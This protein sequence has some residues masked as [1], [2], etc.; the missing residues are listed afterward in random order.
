MSRIHCILALVA[1]LISVCTLVAQGND[2]L[3]DVYLDVNDVRDLGYDGERIWVATTGGAVAFDPES[4]KYD[5]L[6]R[7]SGGLLSDSLTAVQIDHTGRIWFGTERAGISI[8][9][10]TSGT[11]EAYTSLFRPLPSDRI[12]A[13]RVGG[14]SLLVGSDNGLTVLVSDEQR[15]ACL[16]GIYTCELPSYSVLD[17][18]SDPS[19]NGVWIATARGVVHRTQQGAWLPY[20]NGPAEPRADRLIRH[21][22]RWVAAFGS[23]ILALPTAG[24]ST[25]EALAPGIPAGADVTDLLS[26]QS[27][28]FAGTTAGVWVLADNAEAWRM[29]G[30]RAI[31]A[32]S[33]LE[34][35][36]GTLWAGGHDPG[37]L[38]DGLWKLQ[39]D[40]WSRITFPG[41]MASA[42]YLSLSFSP[43]GVLYT[44]TA[45]K[46]ALPLLQH[47]D[48]VL[49]SSVT[50]LQ[51]WTFDL[52]FNQEGKLWLAQCCCRA[53]GCDL[54]LADGDSIV[55]DVPRNLRD[56]AYDGD[57]NLW[58]ASD[59]AVD[60]EQHA[61][62]VW[63]RDAAT[64]V[65][66]Q[67]NTSSESHLLSNRVRAVLPYQGEVWIGYSGRGVHR[68]NLGADRRP[69]TGDDG[70]WTLYSTETAGRR[71][72]DDSITR[73]AAR[74][75]TLWIGTTAGLSLL[76]V[77]TEIVRNISSGPTRLPRPQINAVMPLADGGAWVATG[78]NGGLTRMVPTEG[79]FEYV[80][81]GPPDVPHPNIETIALDPDGRSLWL[82]TNRGLARM[83]PPPEG[84]G[85]NEGISA[86]PNPMIPGCGE[87]ARLLGFSG[88]ADGVVLDVAGKIIARF[89]DLP[90]GA[91]V[92]NGLDA[93]GRE[94]APG[95]YWIRLNTPQ[96]IRSVG[97]GI[98]SG[99]CPR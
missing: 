33:L 19:G 32:T 1:L 57:G 36:E 2:P 29:V 25:W 41:P 63:F 83:T 23:Q 8:H 56:L 79:G 98:G 99:P 64:G 38:L 15:V 47:Y 49:W 18:V 97:L 58:G 27:G 96:G 54:D 61:Q 55:S 86:Y 31:P 3:W 72:I 67:Y 16:E 77:R 30:G 14:D 69:G 12:Q 48:G 89:E 74:G 40:S 24:S 4:G 11:F 53:T 90:A 21:R 59:N 94:V 88:L 85:S 26:S 10:P 75:N 84:P 73:L 71:L 91:S 9:D 87:G 28:L 52:V 20:L 66:T 43:A 13:L 34:T 37:A 17:I 50:R 82:G 93:S 44:T 35:P 62:G 95:L 39:G 92:W 51:D 45:E 68:W 7:R 6:H 76:D 22:G 5:I 80:H 65:W 81:F 70:L 60:Q 42:H 46:G 78:Q